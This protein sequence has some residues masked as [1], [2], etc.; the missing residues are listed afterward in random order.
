MEKLPPI[1][2][3]PEAYSAIADGRVEMKG[4]TATVKSSTLEK[5]YLIKWKDNLY[6][7]NDSSTYWQGYPGYPVLAVLFLQGILPLKEEIVPYFKG[8]NWNVLNKETKRDYQKS[9]EM[10]LE[11]FDKEIQ[12][13]IKEEINEVYDKIKKLDIVITKKKSEVEN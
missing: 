1:E 7:S 12:V 9:L 6:Y 10:V 3:I 11:K 8:I 4:N 2:K 13:C 5:E